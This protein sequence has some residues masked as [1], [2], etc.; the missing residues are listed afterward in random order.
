MSTLRVSNIEAKADVSSPTVDEKIKFTNSSGDVLF[1]LDGKTSGITTVGINT[2]GNTFTVNN[3]TGDVSFSGSVTSSG[4]ST[5]SSDVSIADKIVHIGDTDTAIRFPDADT[6]TAETGGSERL[7]I[8]S[9]GLIGIGTD[10]TPT[11]KLDVFEAVTSTQTAI[12]IGNTNT[13]SSVNDKRLEFVDGTGSTEGTN[14]FTYGYIQGYREGGSNAGALIFGTKPDNAGSPEEKFRVTSG[15]NV[16]I[17]TDSPGEKLHLT[18]TSGNCKLRIDAASAASVDFYNSGTRFSDMFTDA[19][20]SNFIITNRQNAD[21]LFRT[22]GTNDRLRI[23][24]NG[25]IRTGQISI[26]AYSNLDNAIG[27]YTQI[28]CDNHANTFFGQNLKLGASSGSGNY[29]LEVIN[30]HASIGGAGMYIGGNGNSSRVNAVTFYAV[31]ANQSAGTNVANM[32]RLRITADDTYFWTQPTNYHDSASSYLR[33]FGFTFNMADGEEEVLFY[34]P[35]SY[36]RIYYQIY[37]QSGHGSNGYA[38]ILCNS[39]RYGTD[40]NTVDW[41]V[42]HTTYGHASSVGGNVNHNGVKLTRT[43]TYG[44]VNYYVIVKAFSPAGGNPFSTSGLTDAS[45]RYYSR[46]F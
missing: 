46:G 28:A 34:N 31:A 44:N 9:N 14:K 42:S 4:I 21:I 15:G 22:N 19:S 10:D 36:R 17:G 40:F 37:I 20:T 38:Y 6:I 25:Q 13:P 35:D 43:G 29:A 41:H 1:H 32:D 12:R 11:A 39:S 30:Q 33:T 3:T 23:T 45:Y 5:F 26:N 8:T 24:G 7:R 2:T 16:G 27:G 18:T